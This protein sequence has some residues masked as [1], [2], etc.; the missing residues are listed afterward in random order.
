MLSQ[1][2]EFVIERGVSELERNPKLT[3]RF[4]SNRRANGGSAPRTKKT[5]K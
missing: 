3:E 1:L 4:P 2:M 5:S